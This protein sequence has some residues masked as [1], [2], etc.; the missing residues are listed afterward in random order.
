[1]INFSALE[2]DRNIT[3]QQ[4]FGEG[5]GKIYGNRFGI[6]YFSKVYPRFIKL[7]T[8]FFGFFQ[9]PII[10]MSLF[11]LLIYYGLKKKYDKK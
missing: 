1:M 8:N 3:R 6:Y 10:Y 4:Y 2:I 5:L 9:S 7:E 11:V